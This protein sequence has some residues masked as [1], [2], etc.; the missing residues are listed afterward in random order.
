MDD[1]FGDIDELLAPHATSIEVDLS[2]SPPALEK[3][4][5]KRWR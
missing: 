2:H 5:A 3:H 1:K 4:A